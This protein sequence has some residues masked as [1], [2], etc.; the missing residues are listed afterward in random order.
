[1][2]ANQSAASTPATA[3]V[4]GPMAAA[5]AAIVRPGQLWYTEGNE[6]FYPTSR[7]RRIILAQDALTHSEESVYDVLWG[8]KNQSKDSC[9][10]CSI[11]YEG[12]ARA[13]R[14]TKMN[15]KH[16]IER[17]I[18]KGFVRVEILAD[19]LR[20]IPTKYLVFSYRFALDN[21]TRSNR[22]YVVR[23]GNGVLFAHPLN[24]AETVAAGQPDTGTPG[25][26][27]TVAAATTRLDNHFETPTPS[28]SSVDWPLAT[29]ALIEVMGHGDDDAVARIGQTALQNA[30]D[31]T[32]E[33]VAHFIRQEASRVMRNRKLNNPMGMLIRQVPRRF[34][35]E[36]FQIFRDAQRRAKA[37]Q[38]AQNLRF[39]RQ[40]LED[41]A[42]TDEDRTWAESI[43]R[44]ANQS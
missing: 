32:D 28:S 7:V 42:S 2:V 15:A 14:V 21:M 24:P 43:V 37:A 39:A 26:S 18:Y 41:P 3:I 36:A 13:A 10:S 9:R 31:A 11:G 8:P 40:I 5:P 19:T 38:I 30:P 35:G 17:L 44:D 20:R 27:A 25:Q 1:M 12:I 29:R 6:G 34:V 22:L 16:I 33:E 23:T 4:P